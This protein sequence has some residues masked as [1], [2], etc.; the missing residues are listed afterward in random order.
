M[1]F[2]KVVKTGA[3]YSRYQVAFRRRREGKTD[4]YA[5]KRLIA[6]D[7][8]KYNSPK[9]RLVVRFTNSDVICQIVYSKIRGDVVMTSAYS[10]ELKRYGLKVGLTNY[11]AAYAT[12]LLVARRHLKKL[13]LDKKYIGKKEADGEPFLVRKGQGRRPFLANLDVGLVRTTT[14]SRVFGAMKG[15]LDGG[16][17]VP[18]STKKLFGYDREKK[19]LD[20][21]KLRHIIFGG[22]VSDYMQSL[23]KN[24]PSKYKKQFSRY[25]KENVTPEGLE[26]L[27]KKVHVAIRKSPTLVK[28]KK[29][30]PRFQKT[31][32]KKKLT[33]AQRKI[34]VQTKLNA[35]KRAQKAKSKSKKAEK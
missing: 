16:L 29:N 35:L 12:G 9:Y 34:R 4:Y 5:R 27:Y 1:V 28:T 7:K 32:H 2:V 6:Q 23:S 10:H 21:A 19:E 31:H 26:A 11:A 8:N 13:G 30:K 15:A 17:H 25:I 24:N 14:G 33:G 3:F 22:H 18:H 20:A